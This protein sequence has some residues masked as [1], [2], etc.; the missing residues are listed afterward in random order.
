[1]QYTWDCVSNEGAP[2][3]VSESHGDRVQALGWGEG[4][5]S[6]LL[7][8]TSRAQLPSS[9]TG[10]KVDLG[11]WALGEQCSVVAGTLGEWRRRDPDVK[12]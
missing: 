3:G 8:H 10:E 5:V 4:V 6:A 2:A 9:Y 7:S 12:T 11:C 1:M